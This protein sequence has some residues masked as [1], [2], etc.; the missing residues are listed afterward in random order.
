MTTIAF[1]LHRKCPVTRARL[2]RLHTVHGTIDTPHFMPVG[3]QATV[4]AMTPH[5]VA[6]M[7][8]QMILGNTY[9]LFLRPGHKLIRDFGG[10]HEFMKWNRSILTDS[11][12][13]QIFSLSKLAKISEEGVTFDSHV[14]GERFL[15][16][17]EDAIAV[18]EALGSD[19]M[20]ALD[21]LIP[22][23]SDYAFTRRSV[24]QTV[25]WAQR[26][27][28]AQRN[29]NAQLWGIIQGALYKDL[30]KWCVDVMGELDFPGYAIGGLAVGEAITDL[31]ATADYTASMLPEAKPRYLMGVGLPDN[32][33][34]C[35]AMG[36]DLF[37]C[38]VPTRNA[39]NGMIF[40][41]RGKLIIK[42]S[43]YKED[44][45]PLDP[46]CNCYTCR[47]F[48][49]GYIRHL[50]MAGEILAARLN[51][52]HNLWFYIKLME[53]IREALRTES[54]EV[55]RKSFLDAYRSGEV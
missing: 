41:S 32:L 17:P 47:N 36:I 53:N 48:T 8:A 27:R 43:R 21:V 44:R 9:H 18:Q 29:P 38:V 22:S 13:F 31:Y 39:R 54:F 6:E 51:S 55:F 28:D 52:I 46:E 1:E 4:K 2:G 14:D 11:G 15:F 20:M 24:E 35:V 30:R 34:E 42:Q 49:R 37:D 50:Y 45:L 3:T 16:R 5:E 26:C 25:R 40:T 7:G 23:D 19:V 33:V 10:L 12:G